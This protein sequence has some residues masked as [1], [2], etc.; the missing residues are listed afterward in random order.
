MSRIFVGVDDPLHR[1]LRELTLQTPILCVPGSSL[2]PLYRVD[3]ASLPDSYFSVALLHSVG[4]MPL[5]WLSQTRW[6]IRPEHRPGVPAQVNYLDITRLDLRCSR[7]LRFHRQVGR[8]GLLSS[9]LLSFGVGTLRALNNDPQDPAHISLLR[10]HGRIECREE[11]IFAHIVALH[12]RGNESESIGKESYAS[13]NVVYGDCLGE[14]EQLWERRADT[15]FLG[16][17]AQ[18]LQGLRRHGKVICHQ[19][20]PVNPRAIMQMHLE[21]QAI[22]KA[23]PRSARAL[24]HRLEFILS[25]IKV[26]SIA[27]TSAETTL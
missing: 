26:V 16:Q 3:E 5:D 4:G 27:R 6:R 25:R 1:L 13:T 12:R 15:D 18:S 24:L 11:C 23:P 19:R 7:D 17:I 22:W 20:P 21:R 2:P 14:L 9:E 10:Q 8:P